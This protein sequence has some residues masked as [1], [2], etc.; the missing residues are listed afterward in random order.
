MA[1]DPQRGPKREMSLERIVD[2]AVQIADADG[3]GA[4]SMAAVAAR[5]GYTTMSLYRYVSAK[6]DLIQLMQEEATGLPPESI[7]EA[8]GWR[9][10]LVAAFRASV[11]VYLEHPWILDIPITG[12]PATPN[13][14]AFMDVMLDALAETPLTDDERL[15]AALQV[16]GQARWY[17]TILAAYARQARERGMSPEEIAAYEDRLFATLI[18]PEEYP[19]LRRAVD[20]GVFRSEAD[21]FQFGL[22]RTLDGL[23][24]YMAE[25]ESGAPPA[26]SAPWH[27]PE[28]PDVAEDKRYR[29]A[30]KAVRDAEKALRAARK[31]ERQALAEA[32]QRAAR[33]RRDT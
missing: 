10:R 11:Q 23:A 2:A 19:A 25:R 31:L 26:P 9:A 1:A 14:A 27:E 16:T 12:S 32:R 21:P 30:R 20:A 33:T 24:A 17:G 6:D 8:K 22:D 29:E 4:V 15:A 28:A 13:S 5:L 7:R 18:T 3:L